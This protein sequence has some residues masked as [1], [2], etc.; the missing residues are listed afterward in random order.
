MMK[1]KSIVLQKRDPDI[2]NRLRDIDGDEEILDKEEVS[3]LFISL[4]NQSGSN[5]PVILH[6]NLE[7]N[8]SIMLDI[9]ILFEETSVMTEAIQKTCTSDSNNSVSKINFMNKIVST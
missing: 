1:D 8:E 3:V 4:P 2:N 9:P 6:N 7:K 5:T